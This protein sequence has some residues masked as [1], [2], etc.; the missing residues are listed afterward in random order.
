MVEVRLGGQSFL[1][2]GEHRYVLA[3]H[4]VVNVRNQLVVA[5]AW[6]VSK[7]R[8]NVQLSYF[9]L[10]VQQAVL[11][12]RLQRNV[13][14]S[15]AV[16]HI[17]CVVLRVEVRDVIETTPVRVQSFFFVCGRFSLAVR[18]RGTLHGSVR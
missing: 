9:R 7:V 10:C 3:Q 2:S 14:Q 15:A 1:E 17:V 18:C 4:A 12:F 13:V 6:A 5:F 16:Q 11:E 8:I